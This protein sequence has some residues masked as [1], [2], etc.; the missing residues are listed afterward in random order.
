MA[1]TGWR[2]ALASEV[3]TSHRKQGNPCQDHAQATLLATSEGQV[4]VAVASDG[5]GS[6]AR[7]A[8]G[9]RLVCES[10]VAAASAH[11]RDGGRLSRLTRKN[12]VGWI[13]TIGKALSAR[14]RAE[15]HALR[16]YSS[17]L[18]AAI[19]GTEAAAFLQIGD[20]AIVTSDRLSTG[21]AYLFWP[22]HGAFANT[23]NF[24]TATDAARRL[25]FDLSR[26][27]ID[28]VALFTDG[29]ENL[30]LH[31]ASRSVHAPFFDDIFK[32]V[33]ESKAKGLD[34]GLSASLK[35]YLA[36]AQLAERTDD[37]KTL[38]LATRAMATAGAAR[39]AVR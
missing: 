23:T 22:Q 11:F 34:P 10:L 8:V 1:A 2:I 16:D 19:V 30:V 18:L 26:R 7:A 20:G 32:P 36:R 12:A 24:V 17:T 35:H 14:A 31:H 9:S 21:W 13:G 37:D 29:I 27:R 33:R 39:K 6:A 38:I 25:D 3:G 15:G 5:A 4:L 28:E